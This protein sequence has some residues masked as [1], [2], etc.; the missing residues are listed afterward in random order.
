MLDFV[1]LELVGAIARCGGVRRAADALGTHPA[2]LY[3]RFAALERR[4]AAPLF[5]REGARL[6]PTELG[7]A[8]ALEAEASQARLA[9]LN[10]RLSGAGDGIAGPIAVT[11][12]DSLA[13]LVS[14]A[15][16]RFCAAQPRVQVHLVLSNGYADLARHEAEV[17]IRPTRTPPDTLVGRRAARFSYGIYAA[18]SAAPGWIVLDASL[19]SIP[20][21]RWLADRLA[22]EAPVMS[23]NSMWAAGEACAA[24]VGRALLPSYVARGLGLMRVEG[25]IP[26]LTSEVWL[27][28]HEDMRRTARIRAFVAMAAADLHAAIQEGDDIPAG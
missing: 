17:A 14:K 27:L 9:E 3:R 26:E 1:D 12:T 8:V 2:T 4:L 28:T 19:A 6:V 5:Y 22:G 21:S 18:C 23:V 20:S 13:P 11:T 25:P 10:R 16:A 24:G 15:I 7:E